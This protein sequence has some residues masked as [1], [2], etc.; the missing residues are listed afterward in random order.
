MSF[1]VHKSRTSPLI[2]FAIFCILI[3]IGAGLFHM[4]HMAQYSYQEKLDTYNSLTESLAA[5]LKQEFEN[6]IDHMKVSADLIAQAGKIDSESIRT[7]LPVIA[8][9]K[10]YVDLAIVGLDGI[11]YNIADERINIAGE[12]Y[13]L[14]ARAGNIVSGDAIVY[15]PENIPVKLFAIPIMKDSACLGVLVAKV[16]PKISNQELFQNETRSQT[17]IYVLNADRKLIGYVQDTEPSSF[18]YKAITSKGYFLEERMKALNTIKLK[19]FLFPA[20]ESSEEYI[21]TEAELGM[22]EWSVLVGRP[23]TLCPLTRDIIRLTNLMWI[24]MTVGTAFLI[25][26]LIIFQRSADNKLVK[27]MYLDPV[28]GGDN[29][30]KFRLTANRIL[31]NK[32]YNRRKYAIINFDINRFKVI[33]DAYG[34]QKGDEILK[35]I[36]NVIKKWAKPGEPFTRYAADQFYV[37]T[38]FQEDGELT[39]RI[40]ELD[41]RLHKLRF[42]STTKIYYGI[43]HI[44]E[45]QDSIDHM[46]EFSSI[47]KN[48]IKGSAKGIMAF[49]D[50]AAR[51]RLLEEEEIERTMNEALLKEEFHVYLQ[52]KFSPMEEVLQ[53]AEA[54]VR[55]CKSSGRVISPSNFVPVFEKNGFIMELD[56]YM[57]RKVC[58]IIRNWITLGYEPIPISVNISRLHFAN[59]QL[60][61]AIKDIVDKY[62]VPHYFI[63]LELTESAFLQNKQMM[64]QIVTRLREYGF[65]VS[66]DDFGAGYSSLNSLKDLPLDVVKLDGELFR[67]TDEVERGL[68]VIRNTITMAK[69]LHMKVVAEC[70]ETKEQV[71][72]LGHVGCDIIQGYYFAKP[73]PVQKFEELYFDLEVVV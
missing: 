68:T 69:D 10:A 49:F 51:D 67:L 33:N 40:H 45:H 26:L 63:E 35:E 48:S 28:T 66:M 23:D 50:D 39:E 59:P 27:M 54:L 53:G 38:S 32:L 3:S 29:W 41:R 31:G 7:F 30:Y 17:L 24:F 58:A 46:G 4:N 47:A 22:R 65:I 43:Y 18:N 21:W 34:Y 55:W 70:I 37:M 15:T 1:N 72:F 19:D 20:K 56:Y 25:M 60:A 5:L 73:M 62:D 44:T 9:G 16:S 64:I 6:N 13:F 42:T 11:G 36:Y 61:D 52:P 2:L 12:E 57:L 8:G 14:D 71:D